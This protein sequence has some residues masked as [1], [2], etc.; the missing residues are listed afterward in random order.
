MGKPRILIVGGVAGGASAAT[1]ARRVNEEAEIVMF[2]KG[3][4]VSFANC[5]LPYHIGGQIA[6][7]DKLLLTSPEMFWERFR[8]DVRIRHEV[9]RI[10][11]D[12]KQVEVLDHATGNHT[13]EAYDKLI[14]SPGASPIVPPWEGA[15]ASNVFTL[16]DVADM[17]RIKACVDAGQ[18][19]RAVVI[20]A[21]FIGLEMVESLIER[22]MQVTVVELSEQIMTPLDVE[23]AREME[24]AFRARGVALHL[25]KSVEDLEVDGD[26][27]TA[28]R[29]ST[30]EVLP[31]DMVLISIG[32]RPNSKLAA[33]A[34]LELGAN[35]A[36]AVNASLQTS[37]PDI[38]AVGDAAEVVYGVTG[39][40]VAIPLAGPANRN[41]R[42]A[43]E[44]AASGRAPD[45]RAVLGTAVVGAFGK[46]A[47]MTGLSSKA[48]KRAGIES[49]AVYAIRG[50]HVGYYPGAEG[51]VLKLVYAPSTRRVLGAQAVGGAGVDKRID[52]IATVLHFGGTIDDVANLDLAYA[53][54][55][56]SA[57]DP[58]H[59]A[60]FIAQNE[61]NG[62]VRQVLPADVPVEG[63]LLDVRNPDEFENGTLP[64]AINIPLNDLRDRLDELDRG[65]PV[66][67]FCQVGQRG[68]NAARI[69]MQH[70]F[71]DV[72][73]LAG[74]YRMHKDAWAVEAA[75]V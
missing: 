56:G 53:P 40:K 58:L 5:G 44:H 50:H 39:Q 69:L 74:G 6:S 70:G 55:F 21:G 63:T 59:I 4:H 24:Q 2:E 61:A 75:A 10:D 32:V 31:A 30:G 16:R 46:A 47:A 71:A 48:A 26:R 38:Y 33:E 19:K 25:G 45:A 34:G 72:V 37:D 62:L 11:R 60:A 17:D 7:R 9:V 51:M 64:G 57:K 14:L 1:R 42:L 52:V 73:N 13:T 35:K 68:Y 22:G 20:G 12:A 54:Q 41:G 27:V 43:G 67:V 23:M 66:V 29:L 8:V 15:R 28:A 65:K 3:D 49:A 36:I 18:G